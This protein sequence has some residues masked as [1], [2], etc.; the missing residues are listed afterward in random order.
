[1]PQS[2]GYPALFTLVVR[3]L[4]VCKKGDVGIAGD[5]E[6][7]NKVFRAELSS[8]QAQQTG[9]INP[10]IPEP[11]FEHEILFCSILSSE[12]YPNTIPLSPPISTSPFLHPRFSFTIQ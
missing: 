3:C 6:M 12:Y 5:R 4:L 9:A 8:Y 1:M 10:K 11:E 7:V 2:S